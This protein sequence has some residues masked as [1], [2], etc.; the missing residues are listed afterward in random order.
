MM[1]W[2]F[3]EEGTRMFLNL[4]VIGSLAVVLSAC[5]GASKK[6]GAPAAADAKAVSTAPAAPAAATLKAAK[7]EVTLCKQGK[8]VRT[9]RLENL[10]PQGCKLL[11]SPKGDDPVATSQ[12]SHKHCADIRAKIQEKL[13]GAGMKCSAAEEKAASEKSN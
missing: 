13:E 7:E 12:S 3:N 1:E 11:Y 4:L 9:L 10:H 8:E 5:S 2:Q 6:A